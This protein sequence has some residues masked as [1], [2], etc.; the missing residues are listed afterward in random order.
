L[1][2]G[3]CYMA[4]CGFSCAWAQWPARSL[5]AVGDIGARRIDFQFWVSP[6]RDQ[7]LVLDDARAFFTAAEIF[8]HPQVS[9]VPSQRADFDRSAGHFAAEEDR[10]LGVNTS[11][12]PIG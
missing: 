8:D 10:F 3:L 4:A 12:G 7:G 11:G 1:Y 9:E 5:V 6:T 2:D